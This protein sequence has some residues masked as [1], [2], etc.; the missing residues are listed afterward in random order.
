MESSSQAIEAET[1]EMAAVPAM[2]LLAIAAGACGACGAS[3][4]ADQRYCVQCGQRRGAPRLPALDLPADQQPPQPGV[5]P[6]F[7]SPRF[8]PG[9]SL[10]AVVGTLLLAMAIGVFIGR[11][12]DDSS[13]KTATQVVSVIA[14]GLAATGAS[15]APAAA[16]TT[17]AAGAAATASAAAA[18]A[19]KVAAAKQAP[20]AAKKAAPPKAV[21]IGSVG[22]GPGYTN[23]KFTGDFFK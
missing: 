7:G 12:G 20:A 11:A 9:A 21:K 1:T 8:P 23:N 4:A 19:K 13:G 5:R 15:T 18:A 3:L 14:P 10:V 6:M 2:P 17:P 22:T 16:T